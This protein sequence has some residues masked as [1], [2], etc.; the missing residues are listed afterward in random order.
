M[1]KKLKAPYVG[2]VVLFHPARDDK[3]AQSNYA[4]TP[5]EEI[6]LPAI[7][8]QVFSPESGCANLKVLPDGTGTLWRTSVNHQTDLLNPAH[9]DNDRVGVRSMQYSWRWPDEPRLAKS[10]DYPEGEAESD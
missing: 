6:S 8:T 5:I 1:E 4:G 9:P 10:M 2:A 3:S 7:V